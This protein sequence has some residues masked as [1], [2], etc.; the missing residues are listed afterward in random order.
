MK[1]HETIIHISQGLSLQAIEYIRKCLVNDGW[2]P[3]EL[4]QENC[5]VHDQSIGVAEFR[6]GDDISI[7]FDYNS[8]NGR[9]LVTREF[10]ISR[11]QKD[12][13]RRYLKGTH[14]AVQIRRDGV[15][16]QRKPRDRFCFICSLIAAK[17]DAEELLNPSP[18]PPPPPL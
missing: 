6:Y 10:L 15:Y 14:H 5:T 18:P 3:N 13:I 1:T 17:R 4:S 11:R 2:N 9:V 12:V 8:S 16:A 7:T